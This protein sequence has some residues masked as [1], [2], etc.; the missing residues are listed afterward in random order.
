ML[1]HNPSYIYIYIYIYNLGVLTFTLHT[2]GFLKIITITFI[3]VEES[4]KRIV[5]KFC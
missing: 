2:N 1:E 3:D 5:L 4:T